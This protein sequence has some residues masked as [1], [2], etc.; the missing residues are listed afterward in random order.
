MSLRLSGIGPRLLYDTSLSKWQ[1]WSSDRHQIWS[2]C[3]EQ[4]LWQPSHLAVTFT[5]KQPSTSLLSTCQFSIKFFLLQTLSFFLTTTTSLFI[6]LLQLIISFITPPSS[7]LYFLFTTLIYIHYFSAIL[8][9]SNA[10]HLTLPLY[11]SFY[12]IIY[13]S[14]PTNLF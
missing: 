13:P 8:P 10:H 6:L 3:R 9:S 12:I 11:P 4:P 2:V 7:F 14:A 1:I 5:C